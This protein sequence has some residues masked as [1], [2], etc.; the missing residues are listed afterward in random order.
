MNN[1]LQA[2]FANNEFLDGIQTPQGLRIDLLIV[3]SN[4]QLVFQ[5]CDEPEDIERV[6]NSA[7]HKQVAVGERGNPFRLS[8]TLKMNP[9]RSFRQLK[10]MQSNFVTDMAAGT[11][12]TNGFG[13]YRTDDKYLRLEVARIIVPYLSIWW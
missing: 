7:L 13:P 1:S 8:K 12:Q 5:E 4:S 9:R 2:A 3:N 11:P 6:D 10:S